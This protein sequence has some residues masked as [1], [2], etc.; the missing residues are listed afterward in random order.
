MLVLTKIENVPVSNEA[1]EEEDEGPETSPE[2]MKALAQPEATNASQ[3]MPAAS[4]Y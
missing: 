3:G 4:T 1:P 2:L